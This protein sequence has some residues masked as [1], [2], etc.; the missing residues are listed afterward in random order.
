MN[1]QSQSDQSQPVCPGDHEQEQIDGN[2][3]VGV[4]RMKADAAALRGLTLASCRRGDRYGGAGDGWLERS[5]AAVAKETG[6]AE[7]ESRRWRPE[8][9]T[10]LL[11]SAAAAVFLVAF[12]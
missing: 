4:E 2:G 12:R 10:L 1:D 5:R 6:A 11:I 7:P 9:T 3:L 8:R